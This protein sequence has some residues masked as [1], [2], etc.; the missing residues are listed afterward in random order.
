MKKDLLLVIDMQKVY[1]EGGAWYCPGSLE[2]GQRIKG[3]IRENREK[4]D[5]IFTRFLYDKNAEGVWKDYNREYS[6]IN[7][8]RNANELMEVLK[9]EAASFPLYTKTVYSSLSVPEVKRAAKN[10][11]RVIVCGVVA[12][13]C[14]LS[15]AMALIDEGCYVIYLRD[16][17]AG[18]DKKTEEAVE[19]VLS[20]LEPLHVKLMTCREY[21]ESIQ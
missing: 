13:C 10:A 11:G 17:S 7:E 19:T 21:S 6:A 5:V 1:G 16:A 20:G 12:E 9:E 8:D 18:I 4:I 14:V 15:T 2:A 3:L